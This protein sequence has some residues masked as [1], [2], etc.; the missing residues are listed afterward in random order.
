[1]VS[2]RFNNDFVGLGTP[3]SQKKSENSIEYLNMVEEKTLELK[4]DSLNL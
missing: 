3:R 4:Q 1:M 2:P